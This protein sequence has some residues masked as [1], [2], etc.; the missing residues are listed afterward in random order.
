MLMDFSDIKLTPFQER[1][2][3]NTHPNSV[4]SGGYGNGKTFALI[5]RGLELASQLE[6]SRG[7]FGRNT[8]GQLTESTLTEFMM[9][10]PQDWIKQFHK[11]DMMIDLVNGSRIYFR[12]TDNPEKLLSLNLSWF[13]LDQMEQIAKHSWNILIS[14]LRQADQPVQYAFGVCNPDST[15]HWI[16]QDFYLTD[17]SK[18]FLHIDAPSSANPYL[19]EGYVQLMRDTYPEEL[20]KRYIDGQ[21]GNFEG[22]IY[23]EFDPE[24]HLVDPFQIPDDWKVIVGMDHGYRNPTGFLFAGIDPELNVYLFNEHYMNNLRVSQHKEIIHRMIQERQF[25]NGS[26]DNWIADP[27]IFNRTQ[28]DGFQSIGSIYAEQPNSILFTR[29]YNAKNAGIMKV[30]EYLKA[31]KI[32]FFKGMTTELIKEM[33][34]YEWVKQ[35]PLASEDPKEEA[36]NR[37]DHLLDALRYLIY[38]VYEHGEKI[39]TLTSVH[40]FDGLNLGWQGDRTGLP[41]HDRKTRTYNVFNDDSMF[42]HIIETDKDF[43]KKHGVR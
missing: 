4:Y 39:N 15:L 17:D 41:I 25:F 10:C 1:F 27:S 2:V 18:R 36:V 20:A 11:K 43:E 32:K 26:V 42:P 33:V 14:R 7:L 9:L 28:E 22:Q 30:K 6:G 31:G 23:H 38:Y 8:Y 16:Y 40:D 5:I 12:P 37:N 24:K 35:K 3:Y 19:P 13:G 29:G 21:W 34:A